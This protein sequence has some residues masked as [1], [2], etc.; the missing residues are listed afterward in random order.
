MTKSEKLLLRLYIPEDEWYGITEIAIMLDDA[1]GLY[2]NMLDYGWEVDFEDAA[3][4][5]ELKGR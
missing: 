1:D 3:K 5:T 4:L 2:S